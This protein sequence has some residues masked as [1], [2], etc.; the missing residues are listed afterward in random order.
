[1]K[2][3]LVIAAVTSAALIGGGTYTAVSMDRGS[4]GNGVAAPPVATL[5]AA[6]TQTASATP[7]DDPSD[8]S[9][10][11]SRDRSTPGERGTKLTA[12]DAAAA[13][14]RQHPGA[15]TSVDLDDDDA[16]NG[17]W[18]VDLLG[19]DN[20]WYELD[21]NATT[22]SVR[23]HSDDDGGDDSDDDD[24]AALRSA[25]VTA[26]E[27]ASAALGSVPGT[28]TSAELDDDGGNRWEVD[29]RGKDGRSHELHVDARTAKVSA[30]RDDDG[31]DD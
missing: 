15:V 25:T 27:A 19:K 28:V 12:S 10:D 4:A 11:D 23:T 14:L 20:R 21:V 26:R 5:T 6:P 16:G 18:E 31:D 3:N 30:D 22:G 29:V 9:G 8:D 7:S 1:M 2:R 24:R 17:R 13:A